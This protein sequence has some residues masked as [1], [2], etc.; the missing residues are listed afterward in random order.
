MIGGFLAKP[1]HGY[2]I[3][4]KNTKGNLF[5]VLL[6]IS[7]TSNGKAEPHLGFFPPWITTAILPIID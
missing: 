5:G 6:M 4:K 3:R 2:L 7:G 1:L